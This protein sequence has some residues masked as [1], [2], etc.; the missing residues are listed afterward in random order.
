MDGFD[1]RRQQV[2]DRYLQSSF[3]LWSA[4][5]TVNGILLAAMVWRRTDPGY[6]DDVIALGVVG[7]SVIS[8]LLLAYNFFATRV[9]YYRMGE[10]LTGD[11]EGLPERQRNRR[12]LIGLSR[13]RY[14]VLS[15]TVCLWLLVSEALMVLLLVIRRSGTAG[16]P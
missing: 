16:L 14:I 15:E 6:L 10:G 12:I 8:L 9:T 1:P 11:A 13:T 3:G 4:L 2:L 5:L 7:G